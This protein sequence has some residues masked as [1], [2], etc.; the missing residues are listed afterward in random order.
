MQFDEL[1]RREFITLLGGAAVAWPLAARA[2]QA[3]MPVIGMLHAGSPD[4]YEGRLAAF[5]QGLSATGLVEGKDFAIEFR[6]AEGNYER[7]R[8]MARD[9]VDRNVSVIVAAGGV[10]SAPVAKAATATIP[11]V[12]MTGADPI[13]AGLVKSLARPE[14][15][16][17]GV[18]F[19]TQS[20]G[21]KRLGF[22]NMLAPDAT[23]VAVLVNPANPARSAAE[24]EIREA[25]RAS[26]RSIQ[27]FEASTA[28]EIEAAFETIVRQKSGAILVYSDPLFTSRHAQIAALGTKTTIPTIY[29]SREYPEA[30]GLASYGADVRDEYR[31]AGVYTARL[32]QGARPADLPILQPTKFELVLNLKTA[33]SIGLTIPDSF[34]LLADEVIE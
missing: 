1:R 33:R 21:A 29:P 28:A 8:A 19:L 34:Q 6:W 4:P 2:Q 14:A 22:L 20:L 16:V 31:K 30:G 32:L 23:T 10:A 15:N 12:F 25:G 17:T 27:L 24:N 7:L 5:R 11:I 18:S 13:A 9:L 26:R 3:A